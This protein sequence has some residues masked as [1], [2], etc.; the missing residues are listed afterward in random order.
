MSS[1]GR[2]H[3]QTLNVTNLV[4]LLVIRELLAPARYVAALSA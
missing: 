3:W 4:A 2:I 1:S